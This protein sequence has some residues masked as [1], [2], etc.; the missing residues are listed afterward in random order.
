MANLDDV[1]Q[2]LRDAGVTVHET[3]GW[4]TRGYDGQDLDEIDGVLW[5][6]TATNRSQYQNNPAP[7]VAL[8]VNGRWDLAGPLCNMVFGRDGS[9]TMIA[10]GVANHAGRGRAAGMPDDVGNHRLIGIEMES[11][12]IEP[13]DWTPEQ[14]HWA[15]IVGAALEAHY[16]QS[17]PAELRL[18][19]GHM[20]YSTEG[21]IDPAGWPGGMDGLRE[22]INSILEGG[23]PVASLPVPAAPGPVPSDAPSAYEPD[24]HWVVESGETLTDVATFY[25]DTVDA[26]AA[27][28]G[29]Q[30]ADDIHVG[31]W[32]WPRV[33]YGTWMVEPNDTLSK[34]ADWC[35]ANWNVPVTVQSLAFANGLNDPNA[36]KVGQRLKVA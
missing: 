33:G 7:T 3:D 35:K 2:V 10:T 19:L 24:P 22:S 15:P 11:S 26:I 1:V 25:G 29:I 23:A 21:K 28:N 14:L 34:I 13:W 12:G 8:C 5:H 36:I 17:R 20:E 27:W 16:L 31:E 4:I 18:Q 6:H 30:N 9:I 32:I